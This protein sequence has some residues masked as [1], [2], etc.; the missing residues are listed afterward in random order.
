MCTPIGSKCGIAGQ[1]VAASDLFAC[2][3][4]GDR[5][6]TCFYGRLTEQGNPVHLLFIYDREGKP[7]A[8]VLD[9]GDSGLLAGD[10]I[11]EVNGFAPEVELFEKLTAQPGAIDL[12]FIV[13]HDGEPLT[14]S[15]MERR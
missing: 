7:A 15:Y 9:G 8:Y 4:A 3:H 6:W 14:M 5:C 13:Y 10:V 11:I 2:V 12:S 1:C